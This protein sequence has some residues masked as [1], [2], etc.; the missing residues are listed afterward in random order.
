MY[1]FSYKPDVISFSYFAKFFPLHCR[2]ESV[3]CKNKVVCI[4]STLLKVMRVGSVDLPHFTWIGRHT[5]AKG[6][7]PIK[8]EQ[9][10]QAG[11]WTEHELP[12][13]GSSSY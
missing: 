11:L 9:K 5:K 3:K 1:G 8:C 10:C 12:P 2:S 6:A 4:V 13:K 7:G